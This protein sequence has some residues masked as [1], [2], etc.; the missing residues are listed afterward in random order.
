MAAGDE[1]NSVLFNERGEVTADG[2]ENG[3]K[4]NKIDQTAW[5][6]LIACV[7]IWLRRLV[8]T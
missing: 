5:F 3:R 8:V 1:T 2:F 7:K 4:D 6:L